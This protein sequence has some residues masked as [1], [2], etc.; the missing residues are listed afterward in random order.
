[1]PSR[2]YADWAPG[3]C[4]TLRWPVLI[5]RKWRI[6][7]GRSAC[8]EFV[9]MSNCNCFRGVRKVTEPF[10]AGL[11]AA[12]DERVQARFIDDGHF[13]LAAKGVNWAHPLLVAIQARWC[14]AVIPN[15]QG[16]AHI[17]SDELRI[18][19]AH[20]KDREQDSRSQ[21][22]GC[23]IRWASRER[24]RS[25]CRDFF[26]YIHSSRPEG[27]GDSHF[28]DSHILIRWWSWRENSQMKNSESL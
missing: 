7:A 2:R 3:E 10:V 13:L 28:L 11:A 27:L 9:Q 24:G 25:L 14:F 15:G 20:T 18:A 19:A 8:T 5:R 17:G 12:E 1:M 6:Q 21:T 23:A 4:A 16:V 22:W 26:R